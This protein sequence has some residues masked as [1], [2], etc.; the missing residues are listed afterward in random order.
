MKPYFTFL[1]ILFFSLNINAQDDVQLIPFKKG[2][3]YG[4]CDKN[5]KIILPIRYENAYPFGYKTDFSY[6]EGFACVQID[7]ETYIINTEGKIIDKRDDFDRKDREESF[8]PPRIEKV[9]TVDFTVF[10]ENGLKGIK[11]EDGNIIVKPS[12][13]YISIKEFANSYKDPKTQKY[14]NPT[15]ADA[16]SKEESNIIRLDK[17]MYYKNATV[18]SFMTND[19]FMI[20]ESKEKKWGLLFENGAKWFD[21]KFTKI[22]NYYPKQQLLCVDKIVN[23]H[24]YDFYIDLDGNEY[25]EE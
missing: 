20:I 8:G 10:A 25:Y 2:N 11:D 13:E 1:F 22:L 3:K 23:D 21:S 9:K 16:S 14:Y 5:K 12:Y 6:Y 17:L 19:N 7:S 15:Y 18:R 4:Y 24:P